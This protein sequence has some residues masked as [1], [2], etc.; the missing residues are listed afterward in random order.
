MDDLEPPLDRTLLDSAL[1]QDT[2]AARLA[3][4]YLAAVHSAASI[5]SAAYSSTSS[6]PRQSDLPIKGQ[7]ELG[8]HK[9]GGRAGDERTMGCNWEG[10]LRRGVELAQGPTTDQFLQVVDL[11]PE[12]SMSQVYTA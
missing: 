8:Q 2:A 4:D 3:G 10:V 11:Y 5:H 1:E 6:W 12:Q 9:A 7:S